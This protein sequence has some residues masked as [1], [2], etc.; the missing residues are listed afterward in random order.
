MCTL[1]GAV[2]LGKEI[3]DTESIDLRT[4][5][6]FARNHRILPIVYFALRKAG[7]SGELMTQAEKASENMAF[8]QMKMDIMEDKLSEAFSAAKI[9]HYILKGTQIQQRFPEGMTRIS[10][11]TA[12]SFWMSHAQIV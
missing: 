6:T 7:C 12:I 8:K 5:I 4:A 11:D 10:T 9:P 1:I 3:P 2:V